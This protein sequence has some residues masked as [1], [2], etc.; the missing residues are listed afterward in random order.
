MVAATHFQRQRLHVN[1]HN[2]LRI[3]IPP[4]IHNQ[5]QTIFDLP[6]GNGKNEENAKFSAKKL[7]VGLEHVVRQGRKVVI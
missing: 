1:L 3:V 7:A 5:M 2:V 4:T 6:M